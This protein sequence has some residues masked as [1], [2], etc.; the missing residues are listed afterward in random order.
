MPAPRP[1]PWLFSRNLDLAAFTGSTLAGF[2]LVAGAAAA[3]WLQAPVSTPVWLLLVVGVDVAHV[4]ATWLRTYFDPGELK[5][6]AWR[7]ALVPLL[8]W[9][10]GAAL[11]ARSGPLFWRVLAYLAVFHFVRQQLGWVALYQ[12]KEA[13]LR[14]FDRV[15]D[16]AA[17]Y[18]ATL[19]PLLWWHA[20]LPRQ[21]SWFVAGDFAGPVSTAF[22]RALLPVHIFLLTAFF[23]RQLFRLLKEGF[24]PAGK[25]LLVATTALS[26]HVGIVVLDSDLAF[27]ALNVLPHGIPYAVLVWRASVAAG[28]RRGL[29]GRLLRAGPVVFALFLVGLA[30]LEEGLWDAGIWH[31]HEAVFGALLG[32][33]WDLGAAA[34][35]VLVPLLA[36]PQAV[37]YLLD[38]MIWK[39]GT[40]VAGP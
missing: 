31:D 5:A 36:L 35:A 8:A 33:G 2:L 1:Q 13:D 20:H 25:T 27:T 21:F 29:A 14:R 15:L 26:W 30:F 10:A 24:L 23:A 37:H 17:V 3:G 7:Y 32:G 19:W 9:G 12:R 39:R 16:R 11:H 22:A 40:A 18:S 34:Q 6:H 28:P 4:H 38:G